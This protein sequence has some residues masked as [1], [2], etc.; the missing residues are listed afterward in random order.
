MKK[1]TTLFLLISCMVFAQGQLIQWTPYFAQDSDS[2]TVV[3]DATQGNAGLKGYTGEVYAHTGVLTNL[4]PTSSAWRYVKTNWGVNTPETK[5][6]RIGTDLYQFKV[7][8]SIRAFYGVPASETITNICFVFR[9][10][11][12]PTY[13]EGKTASGGDIFLPLGGSGFL[14]AVSAPSGLPYIVTANTTVPV[15][16]QASQATSLS[17]YIDGQLIQTSNGSTISYD[18]TPTTTGRKMITAVA[19]NGTETKRDSFGI[20]VRPSAPAQGAVPTG[21]K[22]GINYNSNN[23][24]VTLVLHAPMKNYIYV[25]GDFSNWD[26]LPELAMTRTPDGQRWW[27][28]I[29]NLI[30][31]TQYGYQFFVDG[32]MRVPDP[33][34]EIVLDPWNDKYIPDAVYPSLKPYPASK[35]SQLVSVLQTGQGS[36]N[37]QASGYQRPAKENLIIYELLIRD[38]IASHSYK[39]I[40]DSIG[41]LK[42]LGINALELMPVNE[43]DGNESWGYNPALHGAIDKY[44]GPRGELKRLVDLCH[45]NGIAVIMDVVFNHAFGNNPMVRLW[46]DAAAGKPASYNPYFNVDATHPYS[47]GY[48][49]NHESQ[50]TKDYMDNTLKYLLTE[51]KVDGFRFDLSKGFTQ[52]NTG[53]DVNAWGAY[54]ASRVAL[55]KRMADKIWSTDASAYVILEHLGDNGEEQE[56]ANYG[57]LLWGKMTDPYNE[58][59]MGY[60]SDL[61]WV[62]YKARGWSK[63]NLVGYMESHDEERL[64]YKNLTWGNSSGNY[65]VKDLGT[66]LDR[67]KAAGAFFFTIPGPKML[68]QFGELGYD[69]SINSNGRVGNKPILWSYYNDSKRIRLYKTFAELIKLKKNYPAFNTDNFSYDLGNYTKRLVLS[70]SSMNVVIVGNFGVTAS[71][72]AGNFQSTGTWY[73][74]FTGTSYNVSNTGS[75]INLQPGEFHIYTS[76]KLPTP[77]PGLIAVKDENNLTYKPTAYALEQNYPNPFNPTTM[78]RYQLTSG[79]ITTLKIFDVLGKEVVTLLNE[80]Q[81]AGTYEVPFNAKNLSSG[82]YYYQIKSGS[83]TSVKKM[84]LMK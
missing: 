65:N 11:T 18:Y 63:Q 8:P 29:N 1:L 68:W 26:A 20:T 9:S 83:F 48:D 55:L 71:S 75:Q 31:G 44:Y 5:L 22:D 50:A 19:S 51:Y 82:V 78:I 47:V 25:I 45:A 3:F 24:S 15:K 54:D 67:M 12:G 43:F 52:K 84:V 60:S 53:S 36:Y 49:F 35:T 41:Y 74:Y 28:T 61:S 2:I 6:T 34:S 30:P 70:H 10:E 59:T 77:E 27:V 81:N 33:Y 69:T 4:S 62:T 42:R 46:W 56:L 64:M 73:D 14:V 76:V 80:Y 58:A 79:N 40:A 37:W 38:F 13:K 23:T 72:I 32:A 17:L 21:M 7:S 39:S 66:A 57:M 16:I